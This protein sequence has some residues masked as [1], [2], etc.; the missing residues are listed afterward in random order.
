MQTQIMVMLHQTTSVLSEP[1]Q[2]RL[3]HSYFSKE[4]VELLAETPGIN[5]LMS[6][7]ENNRYL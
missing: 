4:Q 2:K 3:P 1:L 7:E 6:S 5:M